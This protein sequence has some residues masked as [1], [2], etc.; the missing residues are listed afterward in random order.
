MI[1][2]QKIS[3]YKDTQWKRI[4][5]EDMVI[6]TDKKDPVAIYKSKLAGGGF[7]VPNI[8]FLPEKKRDSSKYFLMDHDDYEHASKLYAYGKK[9][10]LKVLMY[11]GEYLLKVFGKRKMIY[12]R[13]ICSLRMSTTED[14]DD[15]GTE[16]KA[17]RVFA[18]EV[19]D[20]IQL[21]RLLQN[22]KCAKD[23]TKLIRLGNKW[24]SENGYYQTIT[25][26]ELNKVLDEFEVDKSLITVIDD[27]GQITASKMTLQSDRILKILSY[28]NCLSVDIPQCI[29]YAVKSLIVG[30]KWEKVSEKRKLNIISRIWDC[31]WQC[32][33]GLYSIYDH[34]VHQIK[35]KK[36][37]H[38]SI[39]KSTIKRPDFFM[40]SKSPEENVD[41]DVYIKMAEEYGLK[42]FQVFREDDQVP[43][44]VMRTLVVMGFLDSLELGSQM[45]EFR[46]FVI[47]AML[48]MVPVDSRPLI[49]E[50]LINSAKEPLPEKKVAVPEPKKSEQTTEIVLEIPPPGYPDCP[51]CAANRELEVQ[52]IK[53]EQ[54]AREQLE[55]VEPQGRMVFG[56]KEGIISHDDQIKE[57]KEEL[58]ELEEFGEE[59][60]TDSKEIVKINIETADEDL[61]DLQE[62]IREAEMELETLL[63]ANKSLLKQ[64]EQLEKELE[65]GN[66]DFKMSKITIETSEITS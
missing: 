1:S 64:I 57:L 25:L 24:N 39:Y 4:R 50:Y 29:L 55:L 59:Y 43:V 35:V 52:M 30:I 28:D 7:V 36:F 33:E 44:F 8:S 12:L 11:F 13:A 60:F 27:P 41:S 56:T 21:A 2:T 14:V 34:I 40:I 3:K 15:F 51:N 62:E 66:L 32:Q 46:N 9:D 18:E 38:L 48:T 17:T 26:A 6:E 47:G 54:E 42:M 5:A 23:D 19:F 63:E 20:V 16:S 22:N 58:L 45:D 10:I 31:S 53:A 61:E 65:I 49:K 37:E